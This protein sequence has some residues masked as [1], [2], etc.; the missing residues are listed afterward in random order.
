M[1]NRGPN[2]VKFGIVKKLGCKNFN[3]AIW[4]FL[5]LLF[6]LVAVTSDFIANGIVVNLACFVSEIR[7]VGYFQ[8][9]WVGIGSDAAVEF[10]RRGGVGVEGPVP[11]YHTAD[12]VQS[13]SAGSAD[14]NRT[15]PR[16]LLRR[17]SVRCLVRTKI[18][19]TPDPHLTLA[20]SALPV[21]WRKSRDG[22]FSFLFLNFY[23]MT[24]RAILGLY[25]TTHKKWSGA[26]NSTH[27][28]RSSNIAQHNRL[29][30]QNG[31]FII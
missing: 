31:Y 10:T 6:E 3:S 22:M 2:L 28:N 11:D 8:S 7:R 13:R 4:R 27:E 29:D 24:Y 14:I 17:R 18:H 12:S 19:H 20:A 21:W 15:R 1:P 23:F 26:L 30:G 16:L 25:T 9:K 5:A